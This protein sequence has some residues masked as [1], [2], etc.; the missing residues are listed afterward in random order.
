MAK[1]IDSSR[2]I[3]GTWGE[4]WINDDVVGGLV[5]MQAKI[6]FDKS[7]IKQCGAFMTGSK[8]TGGKGT[9]SIKVLKSD[10][11][12]ILR[13]QNATNGSVPNCTIMSNLADPDAFGSERI[14][15][16]GV[17]FDDVTLADYEAGT[18]GNV[19]MPFTFDN[20]ELLDSIEGD[21]YDE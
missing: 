2:V 12:N 17:S 18:E 1:V 13:M 9:G 7:D 14:M 20:Y 5:S 6:A 11:K 21:D 4:V 8:V 16:T 10:S 19:E 3:N 15:L